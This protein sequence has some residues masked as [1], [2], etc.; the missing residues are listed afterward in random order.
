MTVPMIAVDQLDASLYQWRLSVGGVDVDRDAGFSSIAT[1][2][3]AAAGTFPA[4]E[5]LYEVCYRGV[6]MGT[7][8]RS[9]LLDAA[10]DVAGELAQAFSA[11][12]PVTAAAG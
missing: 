3:Q 10:E 4:S 1:C 5:H 7:F 6:H 2:L 8:L 12:E 9:Q 11:L